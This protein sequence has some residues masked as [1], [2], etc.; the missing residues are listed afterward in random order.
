MI[1]SMMPTPCM[2]PGARCDTLGG[3]LVTTVRP[4]QRIVSG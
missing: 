4:R 3:V 1:G 2:P